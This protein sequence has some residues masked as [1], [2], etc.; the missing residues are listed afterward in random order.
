MKNILEQINSRLENKEEW[1]GNLED[2]VMESSQ[3]EELNKQILIKKEKRLE[4]LC[5]ISKHNIQL[6]GVSIKEQT[7]GARKII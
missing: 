2:R 1:I 3:A 7:E 5:D 4:K 6:T